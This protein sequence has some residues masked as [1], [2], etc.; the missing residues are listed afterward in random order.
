MSDADIKSRLT[1][2]TRTIGKD[3]YDQVLALSAHV[4][5]EGWEQLTEAYTE[6]QRIDFDDEDVGSLHAELLP[7]RIAFDG[8]NRAGIRVFYQIRFKSGT[9]QNPSGRL[10]QD[11][12]NWV[13][14]VSVRVGE[15]PGSELTEEQKKYIDDNF[16]VPGDYSIAR[17]YADLTDARWDT[18]VT[19]RSYFG[20]DSEGK[21]ITWDKW[22]EDNGVLK[23]KLIDF[24]TLWVDMMRRNGYT[25]LG[26][27]VVIPSLP[28]QN[29]LDPT[30]PPTALLHQG[31]K[32][33]NNDTPDDVARDYD[34]M[35]YCEQ[36]MD[37]DPPQASFIADGGNW[38]YPGAG[39]NKAVHGTFAIS[40]EIFF[41]RKNGFIDHIRPFSRLSEITLENVI[42]YDDGGTNHFYHIGYNPDHKSA[43]DDYFRPELDEQN[44]QYI[45]KQ[46]HKNDNGKTRAG[47]QY[48]YCMQQ[49][50]QQV[51]VGWQPGSNT[52]TL[53]GKTTYSYKSQWWANSDKQ[54]L[55]GYIDESYTATWDVPIVITTDDDGRL[56]LALGK[57]PSDVKV[58]INKDHSNE[59]NIASRQNTIEGY[60]GEIQ[61]SLQSE[62]TA[63]G[64]N[65]A[66]IFDTTGQWVYP[67]NGTLSFHNPLFNN[68][69]D[70]LAEVEYK[71]IPSKSRVQVPPAT[72]APT[73][74]KYPTAVPNKKS[75]STSPV[76]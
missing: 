46:T 35:M 59:L 47:G 42:I 75:F 12:A 40:Q 72:A 69:S 41:E 63:V 60:M 14:T 34:C 25:T 48:V 3:Y 39:S 8:T 51:A 28:D 27:K 50:D 13:L 45:W 10:T 53:T 61:G 2:T 20:L 57:D 33:Q 1:V 21:P 30:F 43:E 31:F 15:Q 23:V 22:C 9:L 67:G 62:L 4:V 37:H 64:E 11:L 66:K 49:S 24:L 26:V 65:L 74:N 52:I 55:T 5:N 73:L 17:L 32:Y 44:F 68:H 71:T 58:T 56:T 54:D 16:S 7:C 6:L 38:C 70:V 18:I 29:P 76:A 36:L 19:D